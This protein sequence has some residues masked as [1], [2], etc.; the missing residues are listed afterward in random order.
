MIEYHLAPKENDSDINILYCVWELPSFP[1][2]WIANIQDIDL[3]IT[4]SQFVSANLLKSW[5]AHSYVLPHLIEMNPSTF[6]ISNNVLNK[7]K[8]RK[9]T[10]KILLSLDFDSYLNRKNPLTALLAIQKL[11]SEKKLPKQILFILKTNDKTKTLKFLKDNSLKIN[12]LLIIANDLSNE[13]NFALK[14]I[15]DIF[16][17][18]HRSEGFGLNIAEMMF[19]KK[20]VIATNYSSNLDF[21]NTENS[22]LIDYEYQELKDGDYPFYENQIWA[23]P[24]VFHTESVLFEVIKNFG[25]LENI[26]KN[27]YQTISEMNKEVLSFISQSN[28]ENFKHIH[29]Y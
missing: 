26:R 27:A 21:C 17:S 5:G 11:Q 24:N 14:N 25:K 4:P 3:I 6:K 29:I 7:Y 18:T 16:I 20:I 19:S 28:K 13:E 2:E 10:L 15:A 23:N 9:N 12:N 1:P 8:I 22:F